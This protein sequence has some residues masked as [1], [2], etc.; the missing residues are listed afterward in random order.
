MPRTRP[1]FT[2]IELAVVIAIIA[3]LL[4]LLLPAVQSSREQA[5]RLQCVNNLVQ[6][7]IALGNYS[8]T[9]QVLPP[10]V[11]NPTGPIH[12]TAAGYHFGW[13][14][15]ILPYLEQKNLHR[16]FDLGAGLYAANN[17]TARGVVVQ[18][19]TCPSDLTT[20]GGGGPAPG[21]FATAANLPNP[22]LGSY[23]GC[24]D[25]VESPIDAGNHGVF[26][27]NSR[28]SL[29]DIEDG[30]ANT[31][32]VGEKR[33]GGDELGWASGTRATLRNM[34][35]RLNQTALAPVNLAPFLVTTPG[36]SGID[37]PSPIAPE[38]PEP[39]SPTSPS[40]TNPVG[41]F[42]SFHPNGANFLLGDGSVRFLRNSIN[43]R[44]Y[45][46]LGHRAD[47][48]PIGGDQF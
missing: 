25:D 33:H 46:L 30:A 8:A 32:L 28:V 41:G 2:V 40:T 44:V 20:R 42:G 43:F 38:T 36:E 6:I 3:V 1:G 7:G 19:F 10:G 16:H 24:H 29:D 21:A 26:F 12:D 45:R 14:T 31:I 11:V 48:E 18:G 35:T 27:L 23:A 5:R 47:G 37:P 22:A 9:H 15:Q 4:A 39:G 13:M 17:L 34:G